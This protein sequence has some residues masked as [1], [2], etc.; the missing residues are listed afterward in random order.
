MRLFLGAFFAGFLLALLAAHFY[1]LPVPARA[2]S[3]AAALPDGGREEIFTIRLPD[4]KLGSPR[5]AA[6]AEFPDP[7]FAADG[8]R[9]VLAELFRVRD[10]NGE[11]IGLAARL[12]GTAPDF[13]EAAQ[14][15]TDWMLLVPGRGALLMSRGSVAAGG[16]Y[17]F[18]AERMGFSVADSGSVV[19]GSGDF[20]DLA[21][22]YQEATVVDRVAP[23][24]EVY[25]KVTLTTRL[26]TAL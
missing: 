19:G 9:Q 21:G 15:V 18:V 20:A 12:N 4:D 8:R 11:L 3:L 25:G 7:R 2:Y 16:E 23:D 5:A 13:T 10:I 6:T 14:A 22:F 24:G 17:E 26:R 1:P